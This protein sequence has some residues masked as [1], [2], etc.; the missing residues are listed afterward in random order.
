VKAGLRRPGDLIARYAG[1]EFA[2]LLPDT[3]LGG[4]L[5][6]AE[7]SGNASSNSR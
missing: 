4:A 3:G 1:E 5:K 6:L 2:C 7:S